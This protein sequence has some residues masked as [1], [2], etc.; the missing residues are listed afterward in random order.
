MDNA[1]K[2]VPADDRV[3]P[4]PTGQ[5]DR[6]LLIESLMWPTLVVEGGIGSEDPLQMVSTKKSCGIGAFSSVT[7]AR[8]YAAATKGSTRRSAQ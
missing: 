4:W 1:A 8:R 3:L 2:H 6:A 7:I 5:W